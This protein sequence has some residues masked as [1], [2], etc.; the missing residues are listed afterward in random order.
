MVPY[1][2]ITYIISLLLGCSTTQSG[3]GTQRV[4][5]KLRK[6]QNFLLVQAMYFV[7]KAWDGLAEIV[8]IRKIYSLLQISTYISEGE[9][10][11]VL[12]VLHAKLHYWDA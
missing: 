5:I 9:R 4:T 10:W 3:P 2:I 7:Y 8:V 1:K 12:R 11:I 6:R